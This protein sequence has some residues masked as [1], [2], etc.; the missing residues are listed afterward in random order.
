[1]IKQSSRNTE[2][3]KFLS[4]HLR[5]HPEKLGLTMEKGGWV[6]IEELLKA[7]AQNNVPLSLS[8]LTEVVINNDKKRFSFDETGT[9][10]RANQG[11]SINIDL[12]LNP[13]IPPDLLYHGTHPQVVNTILK[14]GIKKMSRHHVHLSVDILTAE[15]VGQRRGKPIILQIDTKK[16]NEDGFIFYCSDNNIWLVDFVPPQYLTKFI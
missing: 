12:Q 15:K 4:Y 2:I 9:K 16:M 13:R 10:I 8:E 3:S 11:H 14:E 1:M 5:H 6:S 7:S